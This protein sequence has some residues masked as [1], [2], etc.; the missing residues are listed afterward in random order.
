[1]TKS[2]CKT[3]KNTNPVGSAVRSKHFETLKSTKNVSWYKPTEKYFRLETLLKIPM[4][5]FLLF[6]K[7]NSNMIAEMYNEYDSRVV[8]ILASFIW[9]NMDLAKQLPF[10][11]AARF[12]MKEYNNL[13]NAVGESDASLLNEYLKSRSRRGID[14]LLK[15]SETSQMILDEEKVHDKNSN[16]DKHLNSTVQNF[17]FNYPME[18]DFVFA[19]QALFDTTHMD[20][21]LLVHNSMIERP[22][23]VSQVPQKDIV[24][25]FQL[26]NQT[27]K[28]LHTELK[29]SHEHDTI[30]QH[31]LKSKKKSD[32]L[33]E[34]VFD[35]PKSKSNEIKPKPKTRLIL[36]TSPNSIQ[37]AFEE[38][39]NTLSA[40]IEN[41]FKNTSTFLDSLSP[42]Q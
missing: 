19:N 5:G 41:W 24:D 4:N 9:E 25:F 42:R 36:N 35:S 3:V 33:R 1:M 29:S 7:L 6:R 23:T 22:K 13:K 8:S 37:M 27:L 40:G 20:P 15:A 16:Q 14:E 28:S 21:L 2:P 38:S 39:I 31:T 12:M 26:T 18:S 32:D 11:N 17:E 34:I 10:T 30:N